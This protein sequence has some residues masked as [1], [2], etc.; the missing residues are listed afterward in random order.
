MDFIFR[1]KALKFT[2]TDIWNA[3]RS[4]NLETL[5]ARSEGKSEA[6]SIGWKNH[7]D[8]L[9]DE[10]LSKRVSSQEDGVLC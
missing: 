1:N 2:I 3:Y 8:H 4:Y 7:L 9:N 6:R 10:Y 5:K